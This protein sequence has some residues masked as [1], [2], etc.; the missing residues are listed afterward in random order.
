MNAARAAALA[1]IACAGVAI[2][3][4]TAHA[5]D[6]LLC[7]LLAPCDGESGGVDGGGD[8]EPAPVD[9]GADIDVDLGLGLV[10]DVDIQLF[11]DGGTL[12]TADTDV[13]HATLELAA[14]DDAL[15]LVGEAM[16]D[17]DASVARDGI[18][19][20]GD[21]SANAQM[22]ATTWR[23]LVGLEAANRF[24]GVQVVIAAESSATC[25]PNVAPGRATSEQG[26]IAVAESVDLCGAHVV[27]AGSA[28]TGCGDSSATGS[29]EA[30][31]S[32]TLADAAADGT[33]CGASIAVAGESDTTCAGSAQEAPVPSADPDGSGPG[34]LGTGATGAVAASVEGAGSLPAAGGPSAETPNDEGNSGT[35]AGES[36]GSLPLTGTSVLLFLALAAAVVATGLVA[37]RSS[38]VRVGHQS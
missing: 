32:W 24:C 23:K 6:P 16:L 21:G 10:T 38:R 3:A 9:D 18:V 25:Q 19:V 17:T 26:L 34:T 35:T 14:A 28:T 8:S 27:L 20:T 15:D 4:T 36:R 7:G 37:V 2:P 30:G 5:D 33:L 22:E 11:P 13:D 12:L 1:L 31:S 29:P